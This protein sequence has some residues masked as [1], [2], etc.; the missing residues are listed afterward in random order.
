MLQANLPK[1]FWSQA[2]QIA[3]Y[4]IN[5]LPSKI[6]KFKSP[7][8]IL[9]GREI[10]ISHLRVF[11]YVCY[12]HIQTIHKDKLDLR[13]IKC[14]FVGYSTSQKGYKC[15]DSKTRKVFV[16]RDVR[17]DETHSFFQKHDDKPQ[18]ELSY[19]VFPTPLFPDDPRLSTPHNEAVEIEPAPE[20]MEAY[21]E[22][23][24]HESREPQIEQPPLPRRNPSRNRQPPAR[25]DDF[26]IYTPRY[27][28]GQMVYHNKV[29]PSYAAFVIELS[30]NSK[31]RSFEEANQSPV[32][33]RAM[34]EELKALDENQTWS[35]VSLLK[36][37]R[38]VGARW[39]Y[40]MK[41][42]SDGTIQRHK[43]RLVARGF[44]QTFGVDYKETLSPVAKMNTVRVLLSVAINSHWSLHQMDVK[45]AF[46]HGE[47]E[48]E[49]YMRL[50]PGHEREKEQGIVCKLHKA[51][52]GLKLHKAKSFETL[53]GVLNGMTKIMDGGQSQGQF[54]LIL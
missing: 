11:G 42:H 23:V 44:T 22:E 47:F 50:P 3:A 17:F 35:I 37:Q 41:F 52:Y 53:N 8:Q 38:V 2:I 46:L 9:K 24:L 18:G 32:W 5:C 43:A 31:P 39:I 40:Q 13:A 27:P 28:I 4:I 34:L 49:V 14:A 25:L 20:N 54:L 29:S 12:V 6:L 19:E 10:E 7:Y 21:D 30:R 36:D 45:N 15:Y 16:S 1:K 33:R 48:E 51:I 26:E